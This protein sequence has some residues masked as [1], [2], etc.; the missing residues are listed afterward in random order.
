LVIAA[1]VGW[2]VIGLTPAAALALASRPAPDAVALGASPAR[3]LA[4]RLGVAGLTAGVI[5]TAHVR[6]W[7]RRGGGVDPVFV[8]WLLVD[9]LPAIVYA[10]GVRRPGT[11]LIGG[12][13]VLGLVAA[14]WSLLALE[15]GNQ[16]AL[17]WVFMTW[18][19]A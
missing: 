6:L 5:V 12:L 16:F 18:A 4:V 9:L 7:G 15:H 2:G 13:G 17:L 8:F 1:L 3:W 19:L 14:G 11:V 10:A